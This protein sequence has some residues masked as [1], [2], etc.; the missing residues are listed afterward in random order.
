MIDSDPPAMEC[1]VRG[2]QAPFDVRL[3]V[4]KQTASFATDHGCSATRPTRWTDDPRRGGRRDD[5]RQV[6]QERVTLPG[7]VRDEAAAARDAAA[8]ARDRAAETRRSADEHQSTAQHAV[9]DDL[10]REDDRQAL[11]DRHASRQDRLDAAAERGEAEASLSTA[12]ASEQAALA[13]LESRTV[14]G[15]AQGLLMAHHEVPAHEAFQL[16]VTESQRRNLKLRTVAA[17]YVRLHEH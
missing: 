2:L 4:V 8:T 13:G 15:Q 11:T 12:R 16:L 5:R 14:I 17:G 9:D 10:D 7:G 6:P 3:P 1:D